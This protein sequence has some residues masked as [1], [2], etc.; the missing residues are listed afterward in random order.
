M[1]FRWWFYP[2]YLWALPCVI[3]GLLFALVVGAR[4]W[5]WSDGCLEATAPNF[6]REAITFGWLIVYREGQ[7]QADAFRNADV[8]RVHERAH[9]VQYFYLG[10]LFFLLYV[11]TLGRPFENQAE[12]AETVTDAWGEK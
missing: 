7:F 8:I 4:R 11:L 5:Q 6:P 10:V 9:V 12:R 2:L 1:K 3:V